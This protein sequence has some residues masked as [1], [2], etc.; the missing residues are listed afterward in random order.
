MKRVKQ[1]RLNP[2]KSA[3]NLSL[4]RPPQLLQNEN[5]EEYAELLARITAAAKP[6]DA[7]EEIF[8]DDVT[9]LQ[10]EIL[11]WQRLKTNLI[12]IATSKALESFLPENIWFDLYRAEF[13]QYLTKRLA[14]GFPDDQDFEA[15][16]RLST[17]V[18]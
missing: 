10:W 12:K 16:R 18:R 2:D 14:V 3:S 11:R 9:R 7:I 4:F 17:K 1:S 6:L 5:L 13:E 8:V 15:R